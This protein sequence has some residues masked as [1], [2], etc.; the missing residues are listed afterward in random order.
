MFLSVVF[1][2]YFSLSFFIFPFSATSLNTALRNHPFRSIF[3]SLPNCPP[4]T[5]FPSTCSLPTADAALAAAGA[6]SLASFCLVLAQP[7]LLLHALAPSSHGL[8]CTFSWE[9][10]VSHHSVLICLAVS[11][12]GPISSSGVVSTISTPSRLRL[13]PPLCLSAPFLAAA[14]LNYIVLSRLHACPF[15][16]SA[17]RW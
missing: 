6:S 11:M 2:L 13:D 16:W 3:P 5:R 15:S 14:P 7:L 1:L 4:H 9:H 17:R 10:P 12:D 8:P